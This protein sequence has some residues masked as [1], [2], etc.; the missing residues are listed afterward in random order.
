MANRKVLR[1]DR[2]CKTCGKS[3]ITGYKFCSPEC[4]PSYSDSYPGKTG[5]TLEEYNRRRTEAANVKYTRTCEAC[6]CEF[7]MRRPSGQAI[8]GEAQEG[9]FCSR[10]CRWTPAKMRAARRQI[11]GLLQRRRECGGC[12][13]VFTV[14][15]PNQR[16]CSHECRAKMRSVAQDIYACRVC[17][18]EFEY[19]MSNG[20]P[21]AFCSDGCR[22]QAK[23]R[24][25]RIGRS[26]RKAKRRRAT[27]GKVDPLQVFRRDGWRCQSCGVHTPSK[28]RGSYDADAPELDHIH[29]LSKGGAHNYLNTQCLCRRCNGLKS[30]KVSAA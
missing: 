5:L 26:G 7:V 15:Q 19:V 10:E 9:R 12:G 25:K 8:K 2:K 16:C 11:I 14:R 30:D 4:R 28:K 23:A 3:P 13:A 29:P 6:G 22:A 20:R 17:G 21:S 1:H 27:V 24:L 18:S